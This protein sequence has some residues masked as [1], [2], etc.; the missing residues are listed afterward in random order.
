MLACSNNQMSLPLYCIYVLEILSDNFASYV[1]LDYCTQ[2][3]FYDVS[4]T[5]LGAIPNSKILY[6]SHPLT[7]HKVHSMLGYVMD[8][9]NHLL[10]DSN[11]VYRANGTQMIA[12]LQQL[13]GK[14]NSGL[15]K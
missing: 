13:M 7:L 12:L 5:V 1:K 11:G 10:T 15:K 6:V 9:C 2:E 8:K 14:S 4:K 3:S